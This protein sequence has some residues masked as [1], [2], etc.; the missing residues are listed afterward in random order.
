MPEIGLIKFNA[1]IIDSSKTGASGAFTA[2]TGTTYSI[3][4]STGTP[5]ADLVI[6]LPTPNQGN[7]CSF[8][9]SGSDITHGVEFIATIG[10]VSYSSGGTYR[11]LATGDHVVFRYVDGAIGWLSDTLIN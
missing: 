4:M 1:G 2:V 10:T 11:L 3:D 8:V 7:A 9:L 6:T 5:S